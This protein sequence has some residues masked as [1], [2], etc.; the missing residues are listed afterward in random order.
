MGERYE[1]KNPEEA[2]KV[3]ENPLLEEIYKRYLADFSKEPQFSGIY[4]SKKEIEEGFHERIIDALNERYSEIK[5][6]IS[7]LRKKGYDINLLELQLDKFEFK[8]NFLKVDFCMENYQLL[9]E[10][11]NEG[12]SKLNEWK[13]IE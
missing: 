3:I 5:S 12:L 10:I 9:M 13:E 4:I 7:F 2:F 11:L 6:R 8:V 1:L